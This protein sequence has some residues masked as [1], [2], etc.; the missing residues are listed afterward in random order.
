MP[1]KVADQELDR[2]AELLEMPHLVKHDG[3]AKV[4]VRRRR[5]E[6]QLDAQRAALAEL[7]DE[8]LLRRSARHSLA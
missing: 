3:M 4:Q 8:L 2:M 7:A 1:V 5:I 6:P